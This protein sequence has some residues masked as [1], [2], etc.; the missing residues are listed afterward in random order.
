MLVGPASP[1]NDQ[2]EKKKVEH[3]G[4]LAPMT[5]AKHQYVVLSQIGNLA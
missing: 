4:V 3:I 2:L 5:A 1:R